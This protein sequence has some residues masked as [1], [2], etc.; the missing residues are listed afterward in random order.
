VG[1]RPVNV[2]PVICVMSVTTKSSAASISI[3]AAELG[4]EAVAIRPAGLPVLKK[5]GSASAALPG[6]SIALSAARIAFRQITV[7]C[8]P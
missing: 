3:L 1:S 2:A 7:R 5:Y 4:R 6:R 8:L